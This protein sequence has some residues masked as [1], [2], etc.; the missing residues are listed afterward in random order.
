MFVMWRSYSYQRRDSGGCCGYSANTS[1][2]T[3]NTLDRV[4]GDTAPDF[5]ASLALSMARS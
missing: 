2:S 3:L 1:R 4:L 5:L